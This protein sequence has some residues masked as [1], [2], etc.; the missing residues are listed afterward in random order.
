M[1]IKQFDTL[2]IRGNLNMKFYYN[3]IFTAISRGDLVQSRAPG[4][5]CLSLG[6]TL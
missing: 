3:S 4:I 2:R 5:S 1:L 6:E